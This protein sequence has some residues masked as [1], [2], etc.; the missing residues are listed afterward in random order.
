MVTAVAGGVAKP[1]RA[2]KHVPPSQMKASGISW[3]CAL[4]QLCR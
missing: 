4:Q 2:A 1:K 3:R